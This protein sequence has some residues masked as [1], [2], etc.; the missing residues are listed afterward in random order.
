MKKW[1]TFAQRAAVLVLAFLAQVEAA[2][3]GNNNIVVSGSLVCLT[4]G[5]KESP[6]QGI[7]ATLAIKAAGGQLYPLTA[8]KSTDTLLREKRLQTREFRLTLRK[9]DG[10]KTF[11]IIKSQ[12]I[13]GGKVYDFFYFCEICNITT[14]TPGP[15]MCCRAPTEYRETPAAN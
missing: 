10:G 7:A 15:C 2:T 3:S 9:T 1:L 8:G 12:L 5:L 13:R 11:Q 6:C 4:S 14:Y